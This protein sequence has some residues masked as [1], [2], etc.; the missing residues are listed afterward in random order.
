MAFFITFPPTISPIMARFNSPSVGTKTV[1]QAGGVAYQQKPELELAS[2]LLTSFVKNEA[3][4]TDAQMLAR[5]KQLIVDCDKKFVAQAAVYARNEYGMRSVSHVVASELAKYTGGVDWAKDFYA[6]VVRRPD[7]I[8]EI[9]AYHAANNGKVPNGM[10]KGLAASFGKF[11]GYSLAKYRGE[12]HAFKL[13]DAANLLHPKPSERNADALRQLMRGELKSVD[14]WETKLSAAGQGGASEDEKIE[15]KREVWVDLITSEKIG[16]FALL[17]NL[18]NIIEQ[19]PDMIGA[20]CRLLTDDRLIKKSLV[21]PFRYLTAYDELAKLGGNSAVRDVLIALNRAVDISL[22]NLPDFGGKSLVVL[23]VS[24]SMSQT[25]TNPSPAKIGALF[26]AVLAKATNADIMVFAEGAQYHSY[27]PMDS[28]MTIANS[29]RFGGGGTNFAAI[30]QRATAK[31]DRVFLLSD[32]QGW[33]VQPG[34]Y[35]TSSPVPNY[36]QYCK[37]TGADPYIYSFDLTGG[38]TTQFPTDKV[39]CVAGYSD[40]ILELLPKLEKDRNALVNTIKEVTF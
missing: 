17:R 26:A 6:A 10:K 16:Y 12:G 33:M 38:G 39:F 18:R 20:A 15:N 9:L 23:D 36:N 28:T 21:L 40:K 13:V 27:N 2:L 3:Y 35:G 37:T 32:M 22:G 5:L 19:A 7:D 1:N 14:T 31:Y 30:F 4:R 29:L 8:T 11:D 34:A 24:G 25:A